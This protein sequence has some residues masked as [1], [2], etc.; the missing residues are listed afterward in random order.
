MIQVTR[1]VKRFGS[2]AILRGLDFSVARGE[3]LH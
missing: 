3:L 1:L 2:K